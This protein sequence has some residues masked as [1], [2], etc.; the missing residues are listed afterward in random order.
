[1]KPIALVAKSILNSSHKG[2][3]VL[4]LFGG[5]GTTILAAEQTDRVCHSM[6]LDEKYADVIIKR[7]I[8]SAG[9]NAGVFLLREGETITYQEVVK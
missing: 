3:L 8:E 4:D 7:Y 6:E 1:M 2:D 5:S 9:S